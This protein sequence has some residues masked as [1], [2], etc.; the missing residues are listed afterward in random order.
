LLTSLHDEA[1]SCCVCLLA[2]LQVPALV[3]VYEQFTLALGKDGTAPQAV[4]LS[5]PSTE[6]SMWKI[7]KSVTLLIMRDGDIAWP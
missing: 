2:S 5:E 4:V 6:A 3:F 7:I 1:Q